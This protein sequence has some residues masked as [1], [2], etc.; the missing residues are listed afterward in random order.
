MCTFFFSLQQILFKQQD[1]YRPPWDDLG[2]V[3]DLGQ[4]FDPLKSDSISSEVIIQQP[5]LN[6]FSHFDF[7][8]H[9]ILE[10]FFNP[11]TCQISIF[12]C[13]HFMNYEIIKFEMDF[14]SYLKDEEH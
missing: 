2:D 13:I 7:V 11:R 10:Y 9:T 14:Y 1:I 8:A 12:N 5:Y 4:H 3:S 6:F